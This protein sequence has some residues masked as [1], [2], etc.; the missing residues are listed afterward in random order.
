MWCDQ[1]RRPRRVYPVLLGVFLLAQAC[2]SAPPVTDRD[3]TIS[4]GMTFTIALD[5][6]AGTGY[7][8]SVDGADAETV[9]LVR[10]SVE[11]TDSAPG[12]SEQEVFLFLAKRSGT[13]TLRFTYARPWVEKS[14]LPSRSYR[15]QVIRC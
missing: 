3:V 7:G 2:A 5:A 10:H 1:N 8:W 6:R 11:R 9:A 12:A 14:P 15:V 13:A 4:E